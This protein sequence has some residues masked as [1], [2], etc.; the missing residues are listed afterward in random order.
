M[1]ALLLLFVARR[2]SRGRAGGKGLVATA[3]EGK[4]RAM[5][6]APTGAGFMDTAKIQSTGGAESPMRT[7]NM[8]TLPPLPPPLLGPL[9]T[10]CFQFLL[11]C[12]LLVSLSYCPSL[13]SPCDVLVWIISW[14]SNIPPH[15][16]KPCLHHF[17]LICSMMQSLTP[18]HGTQANGQCDMH[19]P[20]V[21]LF[22]CKSKV[23]SLN[24]HAPDQAPV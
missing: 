7:G 4:R 5:G 12:R 22:G 11:Q 6:G 24:T 20:Q 16:L 18:S 21:C 8:L 19:V 14:I 15:I 13:A 17:E 10:P 23:P 3:P 9:L 1:L 2:R